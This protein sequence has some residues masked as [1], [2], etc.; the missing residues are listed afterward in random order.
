MTETAKPSQA[1]QISGRRPPVMWKI[2]TM[3]ETT[4][5]TF[6]SQPMEMETNQET[7]EAS[8]E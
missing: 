2:E 7:D 4:L 1:E 3:G 8:K 5:I 6:P